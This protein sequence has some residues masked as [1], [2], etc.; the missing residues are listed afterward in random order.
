MSAALPGMRAAAEEAPRWVFVPVRNDVAGAPAYLPAGLAALEQASA[1]RGVTLVA[2]PE[3]ARRVEDRLSLLPLGVRPEEVRALSE[4][5]DAVVLSYA[6]GDP[7]GAARQLEYAQEQVRKAP[8]EYQRLA[9][10]LMLDLCLLQARAQLE[11]GKL[12]LV[13]KPALRAC[14]MQVPLQ[15]EPELLKH[16]HPGARS[17]LREVTEELLHTRGRLLTLHGP[18]GCRVRFDGVPFGA[19]TAGKRS[20]TALPGLHRVQLL[21]TDGQS[22]VHQIDVPESGRSYTVDLGFDGALHTEGPLGLVSGADLATTTHY[23]SQLAEALG[24]THVVLILTRDDGTLLLLRI[25]RAGKVRSATLPAPEAGST[26]FLGRDVDRALNTLLKPALDQLAEPT[27][28]LSTVLVAQPARGETATP[29]PPRPAPLGELQLMRGSLGLGAAGVVFAGAGLVAH[30]FAAN[31]RRDYAVD[32]NAQ[33]NRGG[34]GYGAYNQTRRLALTSDLGAMLGHVGIGLGLSGYFTLRATRDQA[35]FWPMLASEGLGLS[36]LLGGG[37]AH[38]RASTACESC[39]D[40]RD[41]R[42]ERGTWLALTG[43]AFMAAPL[44]T[45]LFVYAPRAFTRHARGA[46]PA[47]ALRGTGL[48]LTWS[49]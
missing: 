44:L 16:P 19:I 3:A 14:R 30:L 10:R 21:C 15:V 28:S 9:P 6:G 46:Q 22:R 40:L 23:A 25:E 32:Y 20:I 43:S 37:Y 47:V 35:N 2:G 33:L 12:P 38:H 5:V 45:G 48:Q 8:D 26:P 39:A 4:R 18:E 7:R 11:S 24:D 1:K 41:N 49:Y 34:D 27:P 29:L 31:L 42:K 17:L 36:M 13:V